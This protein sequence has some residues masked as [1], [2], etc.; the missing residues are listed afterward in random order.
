MQRESSS[1]FNPED[2]VKRA[3]EKIREKTKR[4]SGAP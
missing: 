1:K 3:A 2:I 4:R